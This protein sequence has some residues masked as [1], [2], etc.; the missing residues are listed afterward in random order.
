MRRT[1][2]ANL[3]SKDYKRP[4]IFIRTAKSG[5]SKQRRL[6]ERTCDALDEWIK[7]R[8]KDKKK[9]FGLSTIALSK[10]FQKYAKQIGLGKGYGFHSIRRGLIT[11]LA[12]GGL[13]HSELLEWFGWRTPT[14]PIRYTQVITKHLDEKIKKVHPLWRS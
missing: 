1:E 12:E 10:I 6:S 7:L 5:Y 13:T 14:M 8:K 4:F 3:E 11:I 2:L 9:L